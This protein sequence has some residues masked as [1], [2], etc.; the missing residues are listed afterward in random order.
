MAYVFLSFNNPTTPILNSR[1]IK[2]AKPER[3]QLCS[4][5][6]SITVFAKLTLGSW[7][8][9]MVDEWIM[10]TS[11]PSRRQRRLRTTWWTRRSTP[12]LRRCS[13][14]HIKIHVLLAA[15]YEAIERQLDKVINHQDFDICF[16]NYF[17]QYTICIER[18]LQ[19]W[20]RYVHYLLIFGELSY[21]LC[22]NFYIWYQFENFK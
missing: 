15:E 2:E 4:R 21:N 1:G 19:L 7:T 6:N 5:N 3:S 14:H 11:P 18:C 16:T 9:L 22:N 13:R 8:L 10:L 17:F 12:E 20:L